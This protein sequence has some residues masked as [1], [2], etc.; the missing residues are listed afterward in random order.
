MIEIYLL[1][2]LTLTVLAINFVP[3]WWDDN[4]SPAVLFAICVIVTVFW[5]PMLAAATVLFL[6]R[7]WQTWRLI[8][9]LLKERWFS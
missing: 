6:K 3:N 8:A 4:E 5:A 1:T 2:G 9:R 7:S